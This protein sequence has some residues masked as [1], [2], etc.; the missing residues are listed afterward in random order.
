MSTSTAD[1]SQP[2]S[3]RFDKVQFQIGKF[4]SDDVK[5]SAGAAGVDEEIMTELKI[6]GH[7]SR[8]RID[9][10]LVCIHHQDRGG[11]IGNS[12]NLSRLIKNVVGLS[13]PWKECEHALC[14]R[15]E[16][17]D[18]ESEDKYRIWCEEANTDLPPVMAGSTCF[19]SLACGHTNTSLRA[20]QQGCRSTHP[21]LSDGE[22]YCMENVK[23]KDPKLADAAV[24]GALVVYYRRTRS[25]IVPR[26]NPSV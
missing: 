19:A 16:P 2:S 21:I 23:R 1:A 9:P 12:M 24:E 17:N 4:D 8:Q 25:Q 7:V 20:I 11:V 10:M 26:L 13:F 6:R 18:H 5:T 15:L 22:Y 3:L 14:M